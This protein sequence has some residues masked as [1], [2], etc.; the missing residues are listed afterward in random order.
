MLLGQVDVDI[1]LPVGLA[2]G[3][4]RVG[5]LGV[6]NFDLARLLVVDGVFDLLGEGVAVDGP[7]IVAIGE[8]RGPAADLRR[9]ERGGGRIGKADPLQYGTAVDLAGVLAVEL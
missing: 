1:G 2:L 4:K 8:F 5:L 7:A 6:R 3:G 9:V